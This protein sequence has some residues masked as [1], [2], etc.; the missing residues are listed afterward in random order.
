MGLTYA[1]K[2][3]QY[4]I[5][6]DA[7]YILC[8][9]ISMMSLIPE[10]ET[11]QRCVIIMLFSGCIYFVIRII[12]AFWQSDFFTSKKWIYYATRIMATIGIFLLHFTLM[13]TSILISGN[14]TISQKVVKIIK[15]PDEHA[16]FYIY[17]DDN[18]NYK[19]S[20][21]IRQSFLPIYKKIFS[22]EILC[23]ETLSV[24]CRNGDFIITDGDCT[25][26]YPCKY[27]RKHGYSSK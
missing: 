22:E 7:T 8:F 13:H 10:F 17:D 5:Y 4:I 24:S 15:M 14:M 26:R 20:I 2:R 11:F 6:L 19:T 16:T 27:H 18:E 23:Q 1:D 9:L 3:I 21:A 12:Q 25:F